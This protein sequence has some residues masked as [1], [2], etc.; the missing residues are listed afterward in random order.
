MRK[1]VS[2]FFGGLAASARRFAAQKSGNAITLFAV[3]A[4]PVVAIVGLGL[5]YSYQYTLKS[6]IKMAT[7]AASMA[8]ITAAQNYIRTY[9]GTSDP[10]NAAIAAGVA[11]AKAQF[12]TNSGGLPSNLL[13][14]NSPSYNVA[15]TNG[16]VT[17]QVSAT[18][19]VPTFLMSVVG[20]HAGSPTATSKAKSNIATYVN[21]FVVID[22]SQSM[23]IGAELSDQEIIYNASTNTSYIPN[24]NG[25]RSAG[26]AIACHYSGASGTY[27]G[28]SEGSATDLT[29]TVR[30]LGATLRIDVAKSAISSALNQIGAGNV[31]VA[32]FTTSSTLTQVYPLPS[33]GTGWAC[34]TTSLSPAYAQTSTFQYPSNISGAQTAIAGIDLQDNVIYP[35]SSNNNNGHG[36]G[37]NQAQN[38]FSDGNGGTNITNA[39]NCLYNQLNGLTYNGAAVTPG[40]G[41]TPY[42]PLSYVILITDG[43]QNSARSAQTAAGAMVIDYPYYLDTQPAD[44]FTVLTS[45]PVSSQTCEQDVTNLDVQNIYMQT[46]DPSTCTPIRES[47]L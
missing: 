28:N 1:I 40:N 2:K 35:S 14:A 22:N 32:L 12:K 26:C 9:T 33:S 16:V 45:C 17:S 25:D 11:Q 39:M 37:G 23:G 5:D 20:S 7:D 42:S 3:A 24:Q 4:V 10:T 18:Y 21:L 6:R 47:G 29:S 15:I 31:N 34:E 30:G 13:A 41:L 36:G 44:T 27:D 43:V 8:G 19:N 46:V 38:A